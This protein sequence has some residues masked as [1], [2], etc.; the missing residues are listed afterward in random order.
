M[1]VPGVSGRSWLSQHLQRRCEPSL[2]LY[3]ISWPLIHL[4]IYQRAQFPL[5]A[6]TQPHAFEMAHP[7]KICGVESPESRPPTEICREEKKQPLTGW[8]LPPP[9]SLCPS[10]QAAGYGSLCP[11]FLIL[12]LFETSVHLLFVLTNV[13]PYLG[14]RRQ[15]WKDSVPLSFSGQTASAP[16]LRPSDMYII[17]I[18]DDYSWD[19]NQLI[20]SV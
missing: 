8:L 14:W 5:P 9:P 18:L 12:F 4:K 20:S 6:T 11:L 7:V 17:S 15:Q 3:I 1:T 13:C 19:R 2:G 10:S 16:F